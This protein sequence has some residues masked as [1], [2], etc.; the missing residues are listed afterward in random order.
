VN[1]RTLISVSRYFA[2][3]VSYGRRSFMTT[4]LGVTA[5]NVAAS[6]I[7][8]PV[9]TKLLKTSLRSVFWMGGVVDKVVRVFLR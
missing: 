8:G 7:T 4:A 6:K 1:A 3:A 9:F 2:T 5:K